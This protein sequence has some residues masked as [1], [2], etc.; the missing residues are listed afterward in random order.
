MKLYYFTVLDIAVEAYMPPFCLRSKL[1]AKRQMMDSVGS[2]DHL[3]RKHP[4]DYKLYCLGEFNDASGL[5]EM[6]DSPE[7]IMSAQEAVMTLIH[8]S[9]HVP[10]EASE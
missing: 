9:V 2:P 5:S 8:Q 3:F 6:Y 10:E 4:D 1:E 7:F